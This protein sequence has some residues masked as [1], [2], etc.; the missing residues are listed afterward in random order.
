MNARLNAVRFIIDF[1]NGESCFHFLYRG[2]GQGQAT[3][4]Q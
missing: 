4:L 2:I 1:R 3:L